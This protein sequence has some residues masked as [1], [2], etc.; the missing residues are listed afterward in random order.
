MTAIFMDGN[1][2]GIKAALNQLDIIQNYLRL[3]SVPVSRKT[4]SAIKKAMEVLE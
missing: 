1:P 4:Y 3:P 2:A